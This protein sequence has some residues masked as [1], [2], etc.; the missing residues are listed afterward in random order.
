MEISPCSRPATPSIPQAALFAPFQTESVM[1]V[2]PGQNS[3]ANNELIED[4]CVDHCSYSSAAETHSAA[5][6][7]PNLN[8]DIGLVATEA[9]IPNEIN[10]RLLKLSLPLPANEPEPVYR[11]ERNG[12]PLHAYTLSVNGW[13]NTLG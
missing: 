10:V 2:Y 13:N 11:Y 5:S 12:R 6:V 3:N 9:V 4:E 8:H 7:T 1:C